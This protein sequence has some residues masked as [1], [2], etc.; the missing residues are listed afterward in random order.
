MKSIGAQSTGGPEAIC[1]A[2]IMGWMEE[3]QIFQDI[4]E[5]AEKAG[6]HAFTS[7]H[8]WAVGQIIYKQKEYWQI[9]SKYL[10]DNLR[11]A[12]IFKLSHGNER[13]FKDCLATD[14]GIAL[15][16]SGWWARNLAEMDRTKRN[17]KK[18]RKV[19]ES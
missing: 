7:Y 1:I 9:F 8:D 10:A 16:K 12:A 13:D 3:V 18:V 17:I 14:L 2:V 6:A 4:E 19:M 11:V 15:K 5:L